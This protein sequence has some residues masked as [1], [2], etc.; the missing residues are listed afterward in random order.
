MDK[1]VDIPAN[2][3]N[4]KISE[5]KVAMIELK[6]VKQTLVD[7]TFVIQVKKSN[8]VINVSILTIL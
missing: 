5:E 1:P 4:G 3:F 7:S 2:L 8:I 6:N